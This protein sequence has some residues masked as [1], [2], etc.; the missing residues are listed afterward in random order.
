MIYIFDLDGTICDVT[1]RL[2][3][4]Q[5][6][7]HDWDA[8]FDACVDDKPIW[9]VIS[10]ARALNAAGHKNIMVTGRSSAVQEQTTAWLKK[11]RVPSNGL[12]MRAAGDHR[13]D[14]I[15]KSEILDQLISANFFQSAQ[16]PSMEIGGVFED[17]QQVVDMYRARGLRVF[18]V[19]PGKF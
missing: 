15:V 7:L 16:L 13:E 10:V 8:F 1:H 17:R 9:E 3:F 6:P 14:H 19:A 18:Q 12:S 4:I 5:S 2:H 11:Y